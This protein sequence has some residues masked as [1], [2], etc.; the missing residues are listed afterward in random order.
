MRSECFGIPIDD[1]T[2]DTA[3]KKVLHWCSADEQHYIV[4][5]NPEMVMLAKK[6]TVFRSA[7]HGSS[8]SLVDGF[9]LLLACRFLFGLRVRRITG[10]DF[11]V[12]LLAHVPK[13]VSF[14]FLGAAPAVAKKAASFT[15]AQYGTNIV[16]NFS[17]RR[18]TY[19]S[20]GPLQVLNASDH[21]RAIQL[22][23]EAR[24]TVLVVALGH[25][26]QEKWMQ[27]FL[28]D[29]PSVRVAFG[30]GGSL[31]YLS[32][33][34]LR[35]PK[36]VRSIGLEWLWRLFLQPH[37]VRRIWT[38]VVLFP[39]E[40]F[41]WTVS[42]RLRYRD[43][44]VA[45]IINCDG[46]VLLVERVDDSEH[47][48]F[49][50]GGVEKKESRDEAVLRELKEELGTDKFHIIGKSM[51]NVY[52]Y[53]WKRSR[54][55]HIDANAAYDRHYGYRGQKQT[56]FYVKFTGVDADLHLDQREH[57]I[58]RWVSPKE[59]I[60]VVHPLRRPVAEIMLRDLSNYV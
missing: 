28:A 31:D 45:C 4:T 29:C 3:Y 57:T 47:W 21:Q 8:L 1:V 7:L 33:T 10:V 12:H 20:R 50:Q 18:D 60:A 23:N 49:P 36:M 9:G 17:P 56:I 14:F 55:A 41:R 16:G 24:P 42:L 58:S 26:K 48:Q 53:T 39:I 32:G 44:V 2:L 52:R 30:V 51:P 13:H 54:H 37:R 11:L 22:I 5:P 34:V 19:S 15:T 35:A 40:V 38:A 43:S 6:D 46:K 27:T 25:G 59:L